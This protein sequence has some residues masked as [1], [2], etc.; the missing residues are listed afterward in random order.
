LK[1]NQFLT[2]SAF[3]AHRFSPQAPDKAT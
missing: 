1:Q 2:C 3:P